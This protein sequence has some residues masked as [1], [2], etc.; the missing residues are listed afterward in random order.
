[1]ERRD[2]LG[3]QQG[4]TLKHWERGRTAKARTGRPA[5]LDQTQILTVAKCQILRYSEFQLQIFY[6]EQLLKQACIPIKNASLSFSFAC[7]LYTRCSQ[8]L[9]HFTTL[10]IASYCWRGVGQEEPNLQPPFT[11]KKTRALERDNGEWAAN[12]K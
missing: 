4:L 6:T 3:A 5:K 7:A 2:P 12:R 8:D 10:T 11:A 9:Q 1:M